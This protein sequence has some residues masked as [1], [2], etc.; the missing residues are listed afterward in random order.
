MHGRRRDF[1][2]VRHPRLPPLVSPEGD[3]LVPVVFVGEP[4][5]DPK[6]EPQLPQPRAELLPQVTVGDPLLQGEPAGAP[7]DQ[8][9]PGEGKVRGR[10][11][12]RP[13]VDV[14]AVAGGRRGAEG[15]TGQGDHPDGRL[16]H[17]V[18]G[19]HP[20]DG[21]IR[22]APEQPVPEAPE[23]HAAPSGLHL[24]PGPVLG[25]PGPQPPQ[26]TPVAP[27]DPRLPAQG[28]SGHRPGRPHG[29]RLRTGGDHGGRP[30]ALDHPPADRGAAPGAQDLE[31]VGEVTR[32]LLRPA[33]GRP[34]RRH[35]DRQREERRPPGRRAVAPGAHR[36][37]GVNRT[38]PLSGRTRTPGTA[39]SR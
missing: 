34:D 1:P 16:E 6:G 26:T 18:L 31:V 20:G 35:A 22:G 9:C 10:P 11:Q 17:P 3:E 2:D 38:A 29:L 27:D 21:T 12:V 25:L 15:G 33:A 28:R 32:G 36:T 8:G 7:R 5:L 23:H 14:D 4:G 19:R 39:C 24:H 37:P 13:D 30:R